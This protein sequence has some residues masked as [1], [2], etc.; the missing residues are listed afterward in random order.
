MKRD[1]NRQ[2]RLQWL[3]WLAYGAVIL[4]LHLPIRR[5]SDDLVYA[6][7][8]QTMS[9]GAF[10]VKA[11]A[12]VNGRFVC[13]PLGA[14]LSTLPLPIWYLADTAVWLLLAWAIRNMLAA[15]LP[16]RPITPQQKRAEAARR[17]R[18][19][20]RSKAG[21][22]AVSAFGVDLS[23]RRLLIICAMLLLFPQYYLRSAGYIMG[24]TN[25]LWPAAAIA[26]ALQ[27][28]LTGRRRILGLIGALYAANQEQSGAVLIGL[29][30]V[31]SLWQLQAGKL[32]EQPVLLA[33]QGAEPE[34]VKTAGRGGQGAEPDTVRAAGRAE[35]GAVP[36][37]VQTAWRAR[38]YTWMALAAGVLMLL[39]TVLAPGHQNRTQGLTGPYTIPDYTDW[40]LFDKLAHGYT[41]TAANLFYSPLLLYALLTVLLFLLAAAAVHRRRGVSIPAMAIAAYPLVLEAYVV[42]NRFTKWR[43]FY[44]Y[45]H[46]MPDLESPVA[47]GLSVLALAAIFAVLLTGFRDRRRG[48]LAALFLAA[49]LCSRIVMGF[50]PT[51]YGSSYRTFIFLVFALL[52]C[53]V[54]ALDELTATLPPLP[55]GSLAG[56]LLTAL[57]L[58]LMLGS[59]GLNV[60]TALQARAEVGTTEETAA[61]VPAAMS[62]DAAEET[63]VEAAA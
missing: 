61:D 7:E 31:I 36:E 20:S 39:V 12:E 25:Y 8:L 15:G 48:L 41:S 19:E 13:D 28:V 2:R 34:A 29:L 32:R 30:L 10:I 18:P 45:S 16:P 37:A 56:R 44:D 59:C 27:P 33:G 26:L 24:S 49:G 3:I 62:E 21:G 35:S 23:T 63:D 42:L 6:E 14:F 43:V 51:L 50:S 53:C 40:T 11:F 52:V 5:L 57:I 54:L 58:V 47:I 55:H 22:A 17:R 46:G 60:L 38:R 1:E 9:I 4:A